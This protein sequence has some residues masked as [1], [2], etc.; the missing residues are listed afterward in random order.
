MSRRMEDALIVRLLLGWCFLAAALKKTSFIGQNGE[1]NFKKETLE[2]T[3]GLYPTTLLL[4]VFVSSCFF[5]CSVVF[6][7]FFLHPGQI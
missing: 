1:T 4:G 7:S 3:D 6:L 5:G 2:E